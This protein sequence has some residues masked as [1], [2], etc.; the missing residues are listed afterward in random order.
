VTARLWR[1]T[2]V[3]GGALAGGVLFGLFVFTYA[4]HGLH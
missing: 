4:A 2:L 3:F 1:R